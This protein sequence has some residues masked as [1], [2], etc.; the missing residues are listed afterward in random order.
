MTYD[1]QEHLL[2]NLNKLKK[3]RS[4]MEYE[5]SI[6]TISIIQRELRIGYN[7]ASN[8]LSEAINQSILAPIANNLYAGQF[9]K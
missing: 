2:L 4:K 3:L 5:E 8:L 7:Q 9:P 1:L 6:I